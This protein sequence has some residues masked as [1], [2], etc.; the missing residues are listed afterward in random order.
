MYWAGREPPAPRRRA[1]HRLVGRVPARRRA[2][3]ERSIGTVDDARVLPRRAPGRDLPPPGPAVPGRRARHSTTTSPCSSRP[4]T[5]TSTPSRARR[6]TSRSSPRSSRCRVGAGDRAPRRGR[7]C[8]NQVVAY[9][10]KQTSTNEVIEVVPLDLP[11]R[12][13]HDPGVLVHGPARRARG[14]RH[15]AATQVLG[16]VH[17][18]EHALIG[19]A[20][21]V[22]DLRPLGRRR[23]VDGAAPADRRADDLRVRRLPGRRRHRRARVRGARPPRARRRSSWCGVPVRR[24][25]PVVRAVAE[26]RQL[27]RVPRQGRRG[28]CCSRRSA[29]LS[30]PASPDIDLTSL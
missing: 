26:V 25:L 9:Q 1:A 13:L 16:A 29:R 20:A 28:R 7:R 17:A 22:H 21:A 19:H 6:P 27:E 8:T 3:D 23:R 2:T 12:T 10:R 14:G 4:T 18:A 24:R 15:R 11:P 5:P 30:P